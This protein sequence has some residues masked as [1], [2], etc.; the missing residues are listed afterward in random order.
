MLNKHASFTRPQLNNGDTP[1][2]LFLTLPEQ[3]QQ[4]ISKFEDWNNWC[5]PQRLSA[6][7]A[8]LR[9]RNSTGINFF[10]SIRT[11]RLTALAR[12]GQGGQHHVGTFHT[13]AEVEAA[14]A[15]HFPRL[16]QAAQASDGTYPDVLSAV[17]AEIRYGVRL[18]CHGHAPCRGDNDSCIK[19]K[20]IHAIEVLLSIARPDMCTASQRRSTHVKFARSLGHRI[21]EHMLI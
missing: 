2:Q 9:G 19:R 15:E 20:G 8:T 5:L 6:S 11:Y 14:R 12:W 3:A 7:G 21:I 17:R 13:A 10:T 16:A 18:W 1:L 4:I